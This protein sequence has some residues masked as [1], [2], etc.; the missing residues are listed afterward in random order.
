[1]AR[2]GDEIDLTVVRGSGERTVPVRIDQFTAQ[3]QRV[4]QQR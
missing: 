2:I 3:R 1:M 4:K